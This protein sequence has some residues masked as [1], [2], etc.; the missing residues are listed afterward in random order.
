MKDQVQST[1]EG[2][3]EAGVCRDI[4][5]ELTKKIHITIPVRSKDRDDVDEVTK[6]LV[7]YIEGTLKYEVHRV[8]HFGHGKNRSLEQRRETSMTRMKRKRVKTR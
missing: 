3:A 2:V 6:R 7:K 5:V 4:K 8:A 1:Y